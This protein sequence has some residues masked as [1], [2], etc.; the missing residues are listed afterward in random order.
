MI[1]SFIRICTFS[2]WSFGIISKK[3]MFN[4]SLACK[5]FYFFLMVRISRLQFQK[6]YALLIQ[7]FSNQNCI[8]R[9]YFN[10]KCS[11]S[12]FSR[13]FQFTL[14]SVDEIQREEKGT[15][16][17]DKSKFHLERA[18]L[19]GRRIKV[20]SQRSILCH[21]YFLPF[22]VHFAATS[23]PLPHPSLASI[24]SHSRF[25]FLDYKTVQYSRSVKDVI[26]ESDN[27]WM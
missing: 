24:L 14:K 22:A 25:C 13:D 27:K 15:T 17:E 3:F 11:N 16:L 8:S 7:G 21:L 18:W 9:N 2:L 10:L 26:H 23:P 4:A 12:T 20:K 6:L 19:R 5:L 1:C